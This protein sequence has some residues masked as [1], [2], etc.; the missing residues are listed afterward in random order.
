MFYHRKELIQQV[1]VAQPNAAFGQFL[2]EQFGGAT[3]ELTAA[4]Q[5]WVQSFHV[6][7]A[8][9]RDMLQDIAIE[10]FSHLEMVGKL[11]AQHTSKI[12]QEA[13][14]RAPIFKIKGGGRHF[15]DRRG[16]CGTA[17][18]I[19]EGGNVVRDLRANI[20]AEAGAR[21]TYEA[22][23]K[24]CED[25]NSKKVLVHL[26]TREITHANMF[27][28]ALDQMGKLDD[29]FFG[30]I[31]P[32]ETVK[33]VFNLSQGQDERGPWNEAPDFD[34]V[35]SPEPQGGFPVPPVNPDDERAAVRAPK[36]RQTKAR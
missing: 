21:Q 14:S 34:Y 27:M 22:L 4:L 20:S 18:Y 33:L 9:I 8:A 16:S 7:N 24:A 35:A 11:I 26:L 32:D 2:L 25:E 30:N 15:L 23:I 6:E 19:Q 31:P 28:K 5:Y 17:A 1:N 29:P 10:E 13:A 12:D 3:G 36:G